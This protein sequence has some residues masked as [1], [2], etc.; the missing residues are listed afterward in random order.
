MLLWNFDYPEINFVVYSETG[1]KERTSVGSVSKLPRINFFKLSFLHPLMPWTP[2]F[3][4]AKLHCNGS[5]T[6]T[7]QYL[8]M[9]RPSLSSSWSSSQFSNH[10]KKS[11]SSVSEEIR[12]KLG[13][14]YLLPLLHYRWRES[15]MESTTQQ[16]A[17][18]K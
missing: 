13:T 14:G 17:V 8:F 5:S 4:L 9:I 11:L 6:L 1:F 10:W 3:L 16:I 2:T 18:W 7:R 12:V 15:K